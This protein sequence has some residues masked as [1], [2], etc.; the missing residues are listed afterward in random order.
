MTDNLQDLAD[1]LHSFTGAT[2]VYIGKLEHPRIIAK[3]SDND[4][5]HVDRE[6]AKVIKYIHASPVDHQYLNRKILKPGQGITH[7]AFNATDSS[8][9]TNK[10][11]IDG[12]EQTETVASSR[13][14]PSDELMDL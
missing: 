8:S 13:S 5:A 7:D 9:P 1:F 12:E 11:A 6:A 3:D 4:K 2:G 10:E 14:A